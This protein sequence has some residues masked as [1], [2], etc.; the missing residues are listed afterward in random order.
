VIH[1]QGNHE[2]VLETE[3]NLLLISK[4]CV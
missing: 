4:F 3:E 2:N 1:I